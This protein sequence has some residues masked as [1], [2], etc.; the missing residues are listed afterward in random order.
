MLARGDGWTSSMR[1][2]PATDSERRRMRF[3]DK[4]KGIIF[5]G[6][7]K[8]LKYRAI[9]IPRS[10][11][12]SKNRDKGMNVKPLIYLACTTIYETFLIRC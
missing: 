4:S 3:I 2:D 9:A 12:D 1:V 7:T 5:D 8:W 10:D 6:S 11:T